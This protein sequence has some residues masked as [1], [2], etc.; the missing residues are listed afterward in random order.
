MDAMRRWNEDLLATQGLVGGSRPVGHGPPDFE[1]QLEVA[2][3]S[4]AA[5]QRQLEEVGLAL[6]DA[7]V[8]HDAQ[9]RELQRQ[10]RVVEELEARGAPQGL[11][12]KLE[13]AQ[14]ELA[15]ARTERETALQ[16]VAELEA[17][18]GKLRAQVEAARQALTQAGNLQERLEHLE[19][20]EAR[21][22]QAVHEAEAAVEAERRRARDQ[23]ARVGGLEEQGREWRTR[24]LRAE[25]EVA[26]LRSAA[27]QAQAELQ[28]L[29]EEQGRLLPRLRSEAEEAQDALRSLQ[30]A[31]FALQ[32]EREQQ[33]HRLQ[34]TEQR[35]RDAVAQLEWQVRRCTLGLAWGMSGGGAQ[36]TRS[37]SRG[38]IQAT[39]KQDEREQLAMQLAA[40][41]ARVAHAEEQAA[42]DRLAL[43]AARQQ[44][45][46]L[47]ADVVQRDER[48]ASLKQSLRDLK[49]ILAKLRHSQHHL[50]KYAL[51]AEEAGL[52]D[53]QQ[54]AAAAV[55][56]G[57]PGGLGRHRSD[58]PLTLDALA[59]VPD[60]NALFA[61]P[62]QARP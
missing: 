13:A 1:L 28:H 38:W 35:M 7:R 21:L 15:Q 4:E 3:D 55:R 2:R 5:L 8:A 12:P 58:S 51:S 30:A 9:R 42:H 6:Q 16:R 10:R 47:Q 62:P 24:A 41:E 27:Q 46:Q 61:R 25:P 49:E 50:S 40:V 20:E 17:G 59:R 31:H 52:S 57:E 56:S 48:I 29:R 54:R 19:A 53:S 26:T 45:T 44:A 33:E 34:A 32:R 39:G 37:A 60:P 22:R 43:A 18:A 14:R 11:G 36:G 23:E